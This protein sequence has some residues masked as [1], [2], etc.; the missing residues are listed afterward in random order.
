MKLCDSSFKKVLTIASKS[1]TLIQRL[2]IVVPVPQMM[3]Q[4]RAVTD[5]YI[6]LT[7]FKSP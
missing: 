2:F 7:V 6:R 4:H 3:D 5:T 1:D